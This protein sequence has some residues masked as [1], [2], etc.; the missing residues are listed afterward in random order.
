MRR[1][2]LAGRTW[3]ILGGSSTIARAFARRVA[4]LGA[5][6]ILAGRDLDDLAAT[7]A[8]ARLHGAPLAI[9]V[10]FDARDAA[11]F[12]GV[13]AAIA[14]HAPSGTLD[15]FLGFGTMPEQNL[16]EADPALAVATVE[17]NY[18]GAVRLLLCLAPMLE[19]GGAGHLVILGS[20]AGDRGRLKNYVYGSAKAGLATFAAGLR[21][22]LGRGG[23]SVTMIKPGF[24]DTAMTWGLPGIFL[25]AAPSDAA[26][27]ILAAALKRRDIVYVPRFWELIMLV[28]KLIPERVFKKLRI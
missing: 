12:D 25:A 7:A 6:V 16:L 13:L 10:A 3:L 1:A 9:P 15:V 18:T 11:G 17:A 28:I 20:V 2:S 4:S 24:L 23:V 27:A 22:R 26:E 8:D 5:G 14:A 19:A 21:N